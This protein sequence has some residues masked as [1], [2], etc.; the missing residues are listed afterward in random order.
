[1]K[2]IFT[3]DKYNFSLWNVNTS[4]IYND[5]RAKNKILSVLPMDDYTFINSN[6]VLFNISVKRYLELNE[7]K[8]NL[9]PFFD[10]TPILNENISSLDLSSIIYL[11]VIVSLLN[12]D[13]IIVFDDVLSYLEESKKRIVIDYLKKNDITFINITSDTEEI[14]L[15][16][17]LIV[18][19]NSGVAIEGKT[20]T[21]L[22][23][24]KLL[25]RLGFNLP[26]LFDISLKLKSY[27]ISNKIYS[28][29]DG[30][31]NEL[32]K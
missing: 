27:D 6:V 10:L 29:I 9:I 30:L 21:V 7:F 16:D 11:K 25:R 12:N 19:T 2:K 28:N 31:V 22:N 23:E 1:M 18:L 5:E 20:N 24:D 26:F 32:W 8:M 4:I 14:L 13:G 3:Y 15:A 17:Y